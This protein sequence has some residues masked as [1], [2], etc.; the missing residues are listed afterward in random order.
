MKS[1]SLIYIVSLGH[2]G[3]TI[4]DLILGAFPDIESL[5]EL[6]NLYDFTSNTQKTVLC[7]CK[8]DFS[9]CNYWNAILR[10]Y[11]KRIRNVLG[12]KVNPLDF[13]ENIL[14]Y[15]T[16]DKILK[17][18]KYQINLRKFERDFK[19]LILKYYYLYNEV[20]KHS[21]KKF[22]LDS[23]K[24]PFLAYLLNSSPLFDVKIIYLFRDLRGNIESLKR[25]ASSSKKENF[26]YYRN[27]I[28]TY[29]SILKGYLHNKFMLRMIE[30]SR[31]LNI[32]YKDLCLY[33]EQTIKKI[34]DFLNI[35]Y[36]TEILNPE[37][38]RFF[39]KQIHHNIGGNRVRLQV[40]KELKYL[41]K[42]PQNLS[43]F[44]KI[45]FNC[46]GGWIFNKIG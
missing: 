27:F 40:I 19:E 21:K 31:L 20:K 2:S 25:K 22:L 23:S 8:K 13:K 26:K 15:G 32:R 12:N 43:K 35:D 10:N 33:P 6:I 36:V 44:E 4:L 24:N 41:Q 7:T 28:V 29:I 37:S 9:K 18:H 17:Y 34:S 38:H 30:P 16:L 3:S 14:A 42:W 46:L 5:G 1:I 39:G 45:A 11:T